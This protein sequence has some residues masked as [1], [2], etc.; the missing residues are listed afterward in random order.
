MGL[1]AKTVGLT[2]GIGSGKSTVAALL[3]E[4]G[5]AVIHAD[6]VGHEI[7]RPHTEGWRRVVAAFGESILAPDGGVDRK[8]LGALVFA[9]PQALKRL[10]AIVHPLMFDDIKQRIAAHRAAQARRPLVLEAAIL[11]E[12]DWLPLVDEVWVVSAGREAVV[13]R[14]VAQRG[15]SAAQIGARIDTQLTDAQRRAFAHRVIEN[16]GSVEALRDRV[17]AAWERLVVELVPN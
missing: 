8:Q 7:Y 12:A 2:G 17:R 11:I 13:D 3:E 16:T 1:R 5:A 6:L 10:N 9:D 15:L 14:L 4:H